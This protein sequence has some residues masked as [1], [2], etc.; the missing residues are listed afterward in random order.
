MAIN[1]RF[2]YACENGDVPTVRRILAVIPE[3]EINIKDNLGRTPLGI[4]VDHEH[5]E[6]DQT[7]LFYHYTINSILNK[8]IFFSQPTKDS[9]NFDRQNKRR[10]NEGSSHVHNISRL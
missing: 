2:M 8:Y 7:I 9:A 3:F 4:A 1:E 6:V 10:A 5:L